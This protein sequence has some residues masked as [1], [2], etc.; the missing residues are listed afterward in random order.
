M[1]FEV[2]QGTLRIREPG[3]VGRSCFP[4]GGNGSEAEEKSRSIQ[5]RNELMEGGQAGS[6]MCKGLTWEGG[7]TDWVGQH[8]DRQAWGEEY[9]FRWRHLA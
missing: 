4:P 2:V 6:T 1:E 7:I 8:K 5:L 9:V 3:P